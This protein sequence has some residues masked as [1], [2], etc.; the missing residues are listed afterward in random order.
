M[1]GIKILLTIY[2]LL[3]VAWGYSFD[4]NWTDQGQ[5]GVVTSES[6]ICSRAGL[7]MFKKGGNAVDAVS[8]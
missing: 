7:S 4:K 3:Q 5:N 6:A 2:G 1:D 8:I